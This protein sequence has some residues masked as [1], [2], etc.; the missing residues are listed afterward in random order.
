MPLLPN[1][2]TR[3]AVALSVAAL[4]TDIDGM[5]TILT[6]L[7]DDDGNA[8]PEMIMRVL[9]S[10]AFMTAQLAVTA[11]RGDHDRARR[12]LRRVLVNTDSTPP[13]AS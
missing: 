6:D 12:C 2:P 3:T 4:G 5:E 11:M 13:T 10:L 9:Y 7:A 1:D 8:D